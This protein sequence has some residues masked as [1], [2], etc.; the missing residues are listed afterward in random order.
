[1]INLV[2]PYYNNKE[3][4]ER[5][6]ASIAAQTVRRKLMVTIIDDCSTEDLNTLNE[7]ILTYEKVFPI[8]Y[9]KTEVNGGPG[10][11]RQVGIDRTGC[12]YIA[13]LDADDL[14]YPRAAELWSRE[15]LQKKPDMIFGYFHQE[16][17]DGTIF[18]MG[19]NAICWLH[20]NV[21][22]VDFLKEHDI[23]FQ[24]AFN[25]DGGFNIQC[26]ALTDDKITIAE[27]LALWTNN[28]KSITR[29]T[30]TFMSDITADY[31]INYRKGIEK[32][33]SELGPI[34]SVCKFCANELG[35]MYSFYNAR[36]YYGYEDN[37]KE[38]AEINSFIYIFKTNKMEDKKD[39]RKIAINSSNREV[40]FPDI[41]KIISFKDFLNEFNY[42]T[43]IEVQ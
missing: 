20:G 40:I 27:P 6:L 35:R 15:I 26:I 4:I 8:K 18:L 42:N 28:K 32:I 24:K 36:M 7:L 29:Q 19:E 12:D 17:E 31:I 10:L 1:M 5:A 33:I 14:L 3:T 38:I 21:Y 34:E 25:E 39:F 41:P 13:F 30:K 16:N 43:I 37:T 23:H 9:V 2:I 22:K 11:T